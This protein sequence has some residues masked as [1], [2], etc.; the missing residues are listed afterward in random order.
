MTVA[1][2]KSGS[3][4]S[5]WFVCMLYVAF[6]LNGLVHPQ[7]DMRTLIEAALGC[8]PTISTLPPFVWHQSFFYFKMEGSTLFP[9]SKEKLGRFF[10]H[11]R[12]QGKCFG[13]Q[14]VD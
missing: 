14:N 2:Y 9:E 4:K 12:E 1:L 13:V 5:L 7:L 6:F 8:I 11:Q 10:G 3:P